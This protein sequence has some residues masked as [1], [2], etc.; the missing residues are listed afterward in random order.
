MKQITFLLI[1]LPFFSCFAEQ[2]SNETQLLDQQI[3]QLREKLHQ[4]QVNQTHNEVQSQE[5]MIADWSAYE[6][7]LEK[8]RKN[9]QEILD[10]QKQIKEL[11]K[12]KNEMGQQK[13]NRE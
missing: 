4:T 11:E 13:M 2:P 8:I 1:L 9:Q 12:K 10:I 3:E 5:Y 7:E 6:N